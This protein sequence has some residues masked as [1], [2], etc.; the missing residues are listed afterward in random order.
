MK[1]K[2]DQSRLAGTI[3]CPSN[4]SYT[5][6]AIF[7]ASLVNGKSL[8]KNVLR[9]RDTNATIEICK[10]LG[11]EITEAGTNLKVK[12]ISKFEGEEL[13][14]DASNSGTTIRIAAAISSLRDGKT[15][16]TGD[17]SLRKR[18]MKP[19]LDAL[20]L[21]GAKCSSND[22]KPPLEITGK[23]KGGEI[24]IPGNVSSQFISALFIAAPLT[25]NGITINISS[26][27]V[28]KPYL[29]ATISTMKKF[30][31][32]VDVKTPYK[33]YY[34]APQEYKHGTITIPS[35][36]SSVALLL[37]A[38]VLVGEKLKVKISIGDLA[39]GDEAILD[40]LGKMGVNVSLNNNTI[41]VE[42]PEKLLGGKF[43]LS[44]T[45]DLLPPLAILGIK[46]GFPLDLHNVKHA[47]FK[48]TD[49][50]AILVRELTKLGLE[51]TEKEDGMIINP[52]KEL[53]GAELN[54]ED[55]HRLFMAFCIAGMYVGG[56]T[57]TDP[58]SVDVSYPS[59]VSDMNRVGAKI[60][61]I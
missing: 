33:K 49:R 31:V 14:V 44:N 38:A 40:I 42:S 36:F 52:P 17:E 1:C 26:E 51:I 29:D 25:E 12:G 10:S 32:D 22:G 59:F 13:T 27:L 20:E 35:D 46:C 5:H 58:E 19:L 6:R 8:V 48:E 34:I 15:I 50:I 41:A 2:V 4:K 3:T 37:S 53:H 43:D 55:D 54:S 23:I 57:V 39:Q 47:R 30:D 28:S 45:P 18:P 9:S 60:A 16:L 7:L 61:T 24:S 11:A 21:L 56:C